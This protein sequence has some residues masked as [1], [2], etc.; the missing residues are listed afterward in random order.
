MVLTDEKIKIKNNSITN[1][2]SLFKFYTNLYIK[3]AR[4]N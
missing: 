4:Q 2:L 3:V 1:K